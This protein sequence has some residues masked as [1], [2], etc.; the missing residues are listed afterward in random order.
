MPAA[1]AM[2]PHDERK[3]GSEHFRQLAGKRK[4]HGGGRPRKQAE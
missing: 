3:H 4:T 1:P 2:G